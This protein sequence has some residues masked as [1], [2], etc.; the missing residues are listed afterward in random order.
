MKASCQASHKSPGKGTHT[1]SRSLTAS[2][3]SGMTGFPASSIIGEI[4]AA[5][6]MVAMEMKR[7]LFA[8]CRPMHILFWVESVEMGMVR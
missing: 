6:R 1:T 4:V 3:V 7:E 8:M 2:S 5:Q